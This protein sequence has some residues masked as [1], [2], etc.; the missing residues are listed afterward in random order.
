[1]SHKP[2][3]KQASIMI[4]LDQGKFLCSVLGTAVRGYTYLVDG[5]STKTW[6]LSP[7]N[8]CTVESLL[9]RGYIEEKESSKH[10]KTA[11]DRQKRISTN[12]YWTL[13]NVGREKLIEERLI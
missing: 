1:M 2:T 4:A 8:N 10:W 3:S 9:N 7:I 12:I 13:S 6:G 5:T 11:E